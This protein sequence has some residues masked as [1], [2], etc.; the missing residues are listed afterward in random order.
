MKPEPL[1]TTSEVAEI[2]RVSQATLRR[3]V[4]QGDIDSVR[5]G[6]RHRFAGAAIDSYLKR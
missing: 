1:F 2:L 3:L 4:A 5:V 6:D